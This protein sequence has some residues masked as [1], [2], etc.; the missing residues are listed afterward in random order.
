MR[1]DIHHASWSGLFDLLAVCENFLFYSPL[2]ASADAAQQAQEEEATQAVAELFAKSAQKN[3]GNNSG[4]RR[5]ASLMGG[6]AHPSLHSR[7]G[8]YL[9]R[10]RDTR[11]FKVVGVHINMLGECEDLVLVERI[12]E[13]L[14]GLKIAELDANIDANAE[15]SDRSAH[16][17][18][19][20]QRRLGRLVGFCFVAQMSAEVVLL[21][22]SLCAFV[23]S[24]CSVSA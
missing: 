18:R 23:F 9:A 10:A 15:L 17:S 14:D 7:G 19:L 24:L 16:I 13:L 8:S 1:M 3:N 12:C 21:C 6:S 4:T 5:T 11:R 2:S 22:S 20:S